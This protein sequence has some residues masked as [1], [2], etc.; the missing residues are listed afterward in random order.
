MFEPVF[1]NAEQRQ[2]RRAP[3]ELEEILIRNFRNSQLN[4]AKN[5]PAPPTAPAPQPVPEQ[6]NGARKRSKGTVPAFPQEQ[7][8][9][10]FFAVIQSPRDRAIFRIMYHAGLR[11]SEVGLLE[12]R[13]YSAAAER[14]MIHRMKGSNSGEH[15]LNREEAEALRV[16]L[17]Q[18]D[19][20]PGPLF[21]SRQGTP[22]SRKMLDVMVK[23]YGALAA[24]P[25][26]LRHCHAFKHAC[27]AHLLSKGFN[28]E[29]VQDWV[30]HANIQSTIGYARVTN[31]RRTEMGRQLNDWR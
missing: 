25:R 23:E 6:R 4:R 24:W 18:R 10:R 15:H 22:I 14:L 30:G 3:D 12:L 7:E 13:D 5:P 27:C 20:G 11:A 1:G 16:W 31:A 2:P 19:T 26:Q 29:Q 9:E 17:M 28:V 8:I 21:A